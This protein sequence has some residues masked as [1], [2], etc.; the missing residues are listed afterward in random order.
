MKTLD[1]PVERALESDEPGLPVA[2]LSLDPDGRVAI[3]GA[4]ILG[5]LASGS[6]V[7]CGPCLKE[8]KRHWEQVRRDDRLGR[9]REG[10]PD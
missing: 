1:H 9:S 7:R 8:W 4:E 3:C 10:A 5:I 6:Y 2:H